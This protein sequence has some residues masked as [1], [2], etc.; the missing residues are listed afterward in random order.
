MPE[1]LGKVRHN[2]RGIPTRGCGETR[3]AG[4]FNWD[5]FECLLN[6]NFVV[7]LRTGVALWCT[8]NHVRFHS[9]MGG[10]DVESYE[11]RNV[12]C[13]V[14]AEG[15]QRNMLNFVDGTKF[16]LEDVGRG[17]QSCET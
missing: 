15:L 13:Q 17:E 1:C 12:Y 5:T 14:I 3:N 8:A 9:N 4:V 10:S 6:S 16:G 11:R 2:G 7:F